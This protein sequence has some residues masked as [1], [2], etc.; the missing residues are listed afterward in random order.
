MRPVFKL[1]LL[2]LLM[3]APACGKRTI[4][5]QILNNRTYDPSVEAGE[6]DGTLYNLTV[7]CYIDGYIALQDNLDPV[8]SGGGLSYEQEVPASVER[9]RI[10]FTNAPTEAEEFQEAEGFLRFTHETF[11]LDSWGNTVIEIND[12]T[13]L[14]GKLFDYYFSE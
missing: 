7:F 3:L 1:F 5:Y 14:E 13:R 10:A 6:L 4:T 9:V 12:S 8:A 11:Y 2:V